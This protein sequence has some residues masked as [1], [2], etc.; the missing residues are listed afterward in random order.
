M[1]SRL[2]GGRKNSTFSSSLSSAAKKA[3]NC[4]FA[5]WR[6]SDRHGERQ[7]AAGRELE[8]FVGDDHHRLGEIERGEG[9]I[10]RQGDDPVGERDLVVFQPDAL[11]AEQ[12]A[13]GLARRDPRRGELRAASAASTTGLA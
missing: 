8:P 10:D 6:R 1:V 13:D 5:A 7:R 12:D 2:S 11:A 4:C 9:R 3:S